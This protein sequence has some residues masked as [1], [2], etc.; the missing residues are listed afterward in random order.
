VNDRRSVVIVALTLTATSAA[1]T[2]LQ[3]ALGA[4]APQLTTEF[5]LQRSQL[6]L[7]TATIFLAGAIVSPAIGR[8]V[9]RFGGQ[10][11]L[12]GLLVG[13][14]VAWLLV[15]VAPTYAVILGAAAIAGIP[16]AAA[17]PAANQVVALRVDRDAQGLVM[18]IKQAGAPFAGV[19]A[20][21]VLPLGAQVL[22]WRTTLLVAAGIAVAMVA[23]VRRWIPPGSNEVDDSGPILGSA[24]DAPVVRWL[25]R[26]AFFMGVGMSATFAYSSLY[27]FEA[28]GL[29][30][31][32]AALT[33]GVIGGVGATATV[34]VGP[35]SVRLRHMAGPLAFLALAA[36]IF[37]GVLAAAS[38]THQAL[39]W[40]GVA[41]FAA[42]AVPWHVLGM[43]A[44]VRTLSPQRAGHGSGLVLRA[45]FVGVIGS[46]VLFGLTVDMTDSYTAGWALVVVAFVAAFLLGLR[47]SAEDARTDQSVV[48]RPSAS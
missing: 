3:F 20:G 43:T 40:I 34:L 30:P 15:S 17:N 23:A 31:T 2:F 13:A 29:A 45:F 33:S 5:S 14:A 46:P 27:A 44:I 37:S 1:S 6:G 12:I 4:L 26:Y 38:H 41:G 22:G 18:G 48:E 7:S 25:T 28:L 19:I 36:A 9:D 16:L 42:T 47:W 32:H 8:V 10:T 11:V 35:Y 21:G 24:G 39:L